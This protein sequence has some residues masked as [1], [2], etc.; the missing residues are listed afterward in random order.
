MAKKRNHEEKCNDFQPPC[1]KRKLT[2]HS[3]SQKITKNMFMS[4]PM[5][6]FINDNGESNY[7]IAKSIVTFFND[8]DDGRYAAIVSN[9]GSPASAHY[10]YIEGKYKRV[11][12][13]RGK[14]I[15][16]WKQP[17]SDALLNALT[18]KEATVKSIIKGL[19]IDNGT[20]VKVCESLHEIFGKYWC[21]SIGGSV[22]STYGSYFV[23]M[24]VNNRMWIVWRAS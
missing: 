4:Q 22:Y 14:S 19:I 6:A 7:E 1:K 2:A 18:F 16:V 12:N 8:R 9:T 24:T 3:I 20:P 23:H 5:A 11:D 13:C 21:A 17:Q 10:W 15:Q